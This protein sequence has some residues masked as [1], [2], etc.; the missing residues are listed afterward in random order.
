MGMT[1]AVPHS[2]HGMR[3]S[4][5]LLDNEQVPEQLRDKMRMIHELTGDRHVAYSTRPDGS[6]MNPY[7]NGMEMDLGMIG[8]RF[9]D[10]VAQAIAQLS[11]AKALDGE[12]EQ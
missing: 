11:V 9:G 3:A 8:G 4:Q 5:A 10:N 12:N 2:R 7:T 1:V 6:R